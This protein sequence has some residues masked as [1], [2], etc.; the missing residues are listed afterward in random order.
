M[1]CSFFFAFLYPPTKFCLVNFDRIITS[2]S[3]ALGDSTWR[4]STIKDNLEPKWD[5]SES[6]DFVF[7]DYHQVVTVNAWD[8]DGGPLDPDDDLGRA[9]IPLG[10]I[11]LEAGRQVELDLLT[12]DYKKTGASIA[13]RVDVYPFCVGKLDLEQIGAVSAKDAASTAL[14]TT[15]AGKQDAKFSASMK[16]KVYGILEVLIL[17]AYD[18]PLKKEDAASYVKVLVDYGGPDHA[19][20][21]VTSTVV[22]YPGIDALDPEYEASFLVPIHS[23]MLLE[24]GGAGLVGSSVTLTLMNGIDPATAVVLGS[25]TVYHDLLMSA[26][27]NE[28]TIRKGKIGDSGAKL[29]YRVTLRGVQEE[30]AEE[31]PTTATSKKALS[32]S[33][34][35]GSTTSS[36]ASAQP[37]VRVTVISGK[38][39]KVPKRRFLKKPDIPDPY[40]RVKFGSN[41]TIHRTKTCRNDVAPQWM[42]SFDFPFRSQGEIV[43]LEVYDE[44]KGKRDPDDFIGGGR[45]AVGKLLLASPSKE[46]EL[47][48][49]KDEPVGICLTLKAEIVSGTE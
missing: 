30:P 26:P 42:E 46:I 33:V 44:D 41:P 31:G 13:F 4:S 17:K 48:N 36:M 49:K 24:N 22:D 18:L 15:P 23:G 27:G 47:R 3:T 38:G 14:A 40:C 21:F 37:T 5:D 29:E 2:R 11:L 34:R 20:E 19:K 6:C 25:T 7:S 1:L 45:I 32:T 35:G 16:K 12:E 43:N 10:R 28:V 8:E 9:E 39:F